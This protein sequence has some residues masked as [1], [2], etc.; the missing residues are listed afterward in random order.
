MSRIGQLARDIA[1]WIPSGT[2]GAF[3][4][5]SA[6]FLHGVATSVSD[7]RVETNQHDRDAFRAIARTLNANFDVMPL[8]ALGEVLRHPDRHRRAVFLMSDDGYANTL[9]VAADILEELHLPWTLFVSSHHVDTGERSPIFL[10]L[11]FAFYGRE[12]RHSIPHLGGVEIGADRGRLAESLV[13][14]LRDFDMA[15][16]QEAVDAMVA[17]FEPQHFAALRARFDTERFLTW[18]EVRMLACRGVE[19]GAHAHRHWPMHT[20]QPPAKL[21]EQAL[22]PKAIIEREVGPCRYFAYPF[23]NDGDISPDAWRAVKDAGYDAAF[24]TLAGS[25]DAGTNRFLLPRYGLA[26]RDPN[27]ASLI[28]LLRAGN[29]RVRR[30]QDRLAA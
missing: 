8:A 6:V 9:T 29:G 27:L 18:D 7:P 13:S 16:A 26:P 23:G 22:L 30:F 17:T 21:R 25:L 20:L 12:G 1:Q 15:R 28:A 11:L 19:I 2:V 10:A 24:T 5:P 4:R 14:R 3:S